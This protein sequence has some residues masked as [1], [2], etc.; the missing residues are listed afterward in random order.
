MIPEHWYADLGVPPQATPSEVKTRW[1]EV[2]KTLHPDAGGSPA[3][4]TAMCFKY[5]KILE[6]ARVCPDC[7]GSGRVTLQGSF[8]V[9]PLLC[10][11]CG[12]GGE[13]D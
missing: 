2:A 9:V 6:A 7:G 10:E 5:K 3:E 8:M 4:F 11:K 1:R 13:I 12:G